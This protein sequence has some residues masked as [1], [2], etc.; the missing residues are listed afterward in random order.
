MLRGVPT[1]LTL[2]LVVNAMLPLCSRAQTTKAGAIAPPTVTVP[3]A[4]AAP[5]A[6][7]GAEPLAAIAPP[8][9]VAVRVTGVKFSGDLSR[10]R[11][12]FDV[13]APIKP[14]IFV[15]GEPTRLIVDVADLQFK[16]TLAEVPAAHGVVT[17]WRYGLFAA[18]KSR[19]VFD[20]ATPIRVERSQILPKPGNQSWQFVLDVVPTDAATFASVVGLLAVVGMAACGV[21]AMRAARV[22]PLVV[23]RDE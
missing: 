13:T 21:P 10:T 18:R 19:I 11:I 23:L 16:F 4:K 14:N 5:M 22:D 6:A 20:A 2:A 17:A 12:V 8:Q 3:T 7:T 15:L 9:P 1:L